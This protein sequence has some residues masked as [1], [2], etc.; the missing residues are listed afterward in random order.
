MAFLRDFE[1]LVQLTAFDDGKEEGKRACPHPL[2]L[3]CETVKTKL[4]FKESIVYRNYRITV[5]QFL[6]CFRA[7]LADLAPL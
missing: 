6:G 7:V 1:S 4:M 5:S 2:I 3:C